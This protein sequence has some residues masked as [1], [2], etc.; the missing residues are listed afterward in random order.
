MRRRLKRITAALFAVMMLFIMTISVFAADITKQTAINTALSD[1]KLTKAK[2]TSL[3][4]EKDDGEYEISFKNKTTGDRYEYEI[5]AR[6]GR[7]QEVSVEYRHKKN[8]SKKKVSKNTAVNRAAK[9]S[10]VSAATIRKGKCTY[11][12]D[13]GEWIYEIKFTKGKYRYEYEVLAPTG[14]IIEYSKEYRG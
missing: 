12:R 9:A 10:G 14:K 13:D 8:T 2:V 4:S 1:A 3:R 6:I 11:K 5:S 7:I